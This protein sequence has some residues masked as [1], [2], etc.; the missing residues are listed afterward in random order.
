MARDRKSKPTSQKKTR[1]EMGKG[2]QMTKWQPWVSRHPQHP[3]WGGGGRSGGGGWAEGE[4]GWGRG[5]K[6]K[7]EGEGGMQSRCRTTRSSVGQ[8]TCSPRLH[9]YRQ[10]KLNNVFG[11]NVQVL[12][13]ATTTITIPNSPPHPQP[14]TGSTECQTGSARVHKN[15]VISGTRCR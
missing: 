3:V 14:V 13:P 12:P 15:L 10:R 9:R 11:M 4:R 2:N 1:Q 5:R 7:T 6:G 8:P